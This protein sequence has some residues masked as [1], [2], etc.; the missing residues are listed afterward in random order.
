MEFALSARGLSYISSLPIDD[1]FTFQIGGRSIECHKLQASFIS[2]I[3]SK[4]LLSDPMLDTLS[5]TADSDSE[6]AYQCLDSLLKGEMIKIN[7][8]NAK[9]LLMIGVELGNT[10]L[11]DAVNN[12]FQ[13]ELTKEDAICLLQQ[14][15]IRN[16]D[17]YDE[18]G[19]IAG[20]FG[21]FT[22]DEISI[23]D[24]SII[25]S[26]LSMDNLQ[27]PSENWLFNM[28]FQIIEKNGKDYMPL[29]ECLMLEFLGEE[30]MNQFIGMIDP[31]K[32]S[33]ELWRAVCRRLIR[34]SSASDGMSSRHEES[35]DQLS[36]LDSTNIEMNENPMNGVVAYFKSLSNSRTVKEEDIVITTSS[37][38]NNSPIQLSDFEWNEYFYTSNRPN[39][40]IQYEL[41][42]NKLALTGYTLRSVG[43]QTH[44]LRNW[45]LEGSEDGHTWTILDQQENNQSLNSDHGV[46]AISLEEKSNPMRY[47][48]ITQTGPTSD[49]LN[50]FILSN[51]ELF[52]GLIE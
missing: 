32:I 9:N 52:G 29:L 19:F 15:L 16:E 31:E 2:P 37:I 10:E 49:N 11:I 47:F 45:K 36:E 17:V 48:R 12:V 22:C 1:R 34:S 28:V 18:I 38:A 26:I 21:E 40:W 42:H 44:F 25:Y 41:K 4:Q 43:H 24:P 13:G 6:G 39:S 27:I 35:I 46:L 30:E 7:S 23:L 5:L 20:H 3:L 8:N 14:R 50:L 33:A 51:L